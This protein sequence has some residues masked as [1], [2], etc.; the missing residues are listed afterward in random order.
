MLCMH[1]HQPSLANAANGYLL[2]GRPNATLSA[3]A[4]R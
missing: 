3:S 4:W 2:D 1:Y